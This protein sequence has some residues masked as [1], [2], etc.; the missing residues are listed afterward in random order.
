M[1]K[2]SINHV[3]QPQPQI[4][5]HL[6]SSSSSTN[7]SNSLPNAFHDFLVNS[8]DFSFLIQ[9]LEKEN[10]QLKESLKKTE[11]A[12]FKLEMKYYGMEKRVQELEKELK[13][14]KEGLEKNEITTKGDKSLKSEKNGNFEEEEEDDDDETS[15]RRRSTP[16]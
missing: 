8:G 10:K 5:S 6:S 11:D 14:L 3:P 1:R 13:I 12:K 15:D 9:K 16:E 4:K 2:H 7:L